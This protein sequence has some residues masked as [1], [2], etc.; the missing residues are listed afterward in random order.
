MSLNS[1]ISLTRCSL[2]PLRAFHR[3][4]GYKLEDIAICQIY[5]EVAFELIIFHCETE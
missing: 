2:D 3:C 1:A 5:L 4:L